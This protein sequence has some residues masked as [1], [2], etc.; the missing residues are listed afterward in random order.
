VDVGFGEEQFEQ[1]ASTAGGALV[2]RGTRVPVRS[3]V[4]SLAEGA[5]EMDILSAF[6]TLTPE[7]VRAVVVFAASLALQLT[8]EASAE[9]TGG[10]DDRA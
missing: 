10:A 6:P 5:T 8:R 4:A 9:E 7:H 2:L 3:V 1:R